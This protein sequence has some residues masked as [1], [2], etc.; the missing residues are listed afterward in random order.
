MKAV[1]FLEC[2]EGD[3]PEDMISAEPKAVGKAGGVEWAHRLFIAN[4]FH[5]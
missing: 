1:L 3:I 5:L 4:K 2:S